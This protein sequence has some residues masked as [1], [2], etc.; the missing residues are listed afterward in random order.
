[1]NIHCH[2]Q[3]SAEECLKNASLLLEIGTWSRSWSKNCPNPTSMAVKFSSSTTTWLMAMLVTMRVD[4][5]GL[6]FWPT[7]GEINPRTNTIIK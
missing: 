4:G 6:S 7:L 1:M 3:P 2:L 5:K